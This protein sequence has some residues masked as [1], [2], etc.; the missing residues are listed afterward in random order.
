[1]SEKFKCDWTRAVI[2]PQIRKENE[3]T[4]DVLH[5]V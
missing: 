2:R 4:L 1:M 5:E 3:Y